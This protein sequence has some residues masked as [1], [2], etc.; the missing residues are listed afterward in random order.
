MVK[1]KSLN[2]DPCEF[3]EK[4]FEH[5]S[6]TAA[7]AAAALAEFGLLASKALA[8][9]GRKE[10]GTCD[11]CAERYQ[12]VTQIYGHY[13]VFDRKDDIRVRRRVGTS[14]YGRCAACGSMIHVRNN[15]RWTL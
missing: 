4:T 3:L 5:L 2:Q 14:I 1:V 11:V 9:P 13:S 12:E 6:F 10:F 15:K 7:Q 8:P